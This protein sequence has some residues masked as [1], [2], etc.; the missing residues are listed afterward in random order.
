ME[1]SSECSNNGSKKLDFKKL[2]FPRKDALLIK[3]IISIR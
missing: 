1:R 2:H 3:L